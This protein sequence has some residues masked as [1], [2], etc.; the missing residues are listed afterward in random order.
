MYENF[1]PS[2]HWEGY[3]WCGNLPDGTKMRFESEEAYLEYL[4]DVWGR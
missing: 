1:R 3:S 2:G 4:S